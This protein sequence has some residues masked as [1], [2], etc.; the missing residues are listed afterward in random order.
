VYAGHVETGP[1]YCDSTDL[2][3]LYSPR[4]AA[5]ISLYLPTS[6]YISLYLPMA[7][8]TAACS[9]ALMRDLPYWVSPTT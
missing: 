5:Y 8:L 7:I 1:A 9:M 4:P 6:P 2:P 3:W